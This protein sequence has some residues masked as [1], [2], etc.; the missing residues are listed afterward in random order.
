MTPFTFPW[1]NALDT[2]LGLG[3]I[4]IPSDTRRAP[5]PTWLRRAF[6]VAQIEAGHRLYDPTEA[7][8]LPLIRGQEELAAIRLRNAS[9]ELY[10]YGSPTLA[11]T[12]TDETGQDWH[13]LV[14]SN[15]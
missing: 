4:V 6:E 2:P 11:F 7:L 1:S 13:V 14:L 3:V 8:L 9:I 15:S 5:W 12:S 10:D